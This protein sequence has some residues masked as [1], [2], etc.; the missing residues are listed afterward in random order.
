MAGEPFAGVDLNNYEPAGSDSAPETDKSLEVSGESTPENQST[1]ESTQTTAEKLADLDKLERVRFGGKELSVK[2]LKESLMRHSDYTKKTQ[3]V[4]EARKYA[5]NFHYDFLKVIRQPSLLAEFKQIYPKQYVQAVEEYLKQN[6]PAT[7]QEQVSGEGETSQA[8]MR[9]LEERLKPFEEKFQSVDSL[10]QSIREQETQA[11]SDQLDTI[12][13]K[14]GQKYPFADP[15][16]VDFRVGLAKEKGVEVT[17]ENL[18]HVYEQIYK[19]LHEHHEKRL[20]AQQKAKVT[21]QVK[22]GRAAR[23][24]KGGTGIPAAPPKKY[25]KFSDI[26]KDVFSSLGV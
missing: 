16:L 25:E 24:V 8:M 19:G 20:T 18:S 13:E 10:M 5:E 1:P 11:I 22:A 6:Q 17:K 7:E 26:N 14:L 2:E 21:E 4:A 12:H 3:E 9:L 23:D 15:D